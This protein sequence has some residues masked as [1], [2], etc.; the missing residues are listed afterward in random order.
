M[1]EFGRSLHSERIKAASLP[2]VP[3]ASLAILAVGAILSI[4]FAVSRGG[5]DQMTAL[6]I[7]LAPIG[8]IQAG[9]VAI[10]T[11]LVTSE[12]SGGQLA[13]SLAGVPR[14]VTF[15]STKLVVVG[16][17]G[18]AVGVVAVAVSVLVAVLSGATAVG[19]VRGVSWGLG[20]AIYLASICLISASVALLMR[21]TLPTLCVVL[22]YYFIVGPLVRDRYS[23]AQFLPDS[24]GY[25]IA[26]PGRSTSEITLGALVL[27]AWC[28]GIAFLGVWRFR[29][30]D[31]R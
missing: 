9:F 25:S 20:G 29:R 19:L 28:V 14:R 17:V 31:A 10:G 2:A 7:G 13:T 15:C 1:S 6:D 30:T 11:L 5:D 18:V 3:M 16:S 23:I 24:A 22:V 8:Y 27:A 26:F 4:A 21:R 12:F